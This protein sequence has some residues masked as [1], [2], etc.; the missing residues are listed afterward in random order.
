MITFSMDPVTHALAGAVLKQ[1]GFKRKWALGVL[2]LSSVA[3]DFD[4]ITRF[5]GMDIFLRYHRGI[6]HGIL[7]LL[8]VPAITGL[9]F[10]RKKGF[11]Y[12]YAISFLG[13]GS[14]LLMDLTTQ[15][16]TRILS[17]LDW[18]QYS[19]DL[20]FIIDPYITLGLLLCVIIG[21]LNI[22]KAPVIAALTLVLLVSY[23]G[24]RHY[25]HNRAEDFLRARVD[26]NTY[27]MCPLPNGFLRWWFVTRSGDEIMTGVADLFLQ[28]ICIQEKYAANP[29]N[30]LI[31]RSKEERAVKNFLYFAK[32]PQA[33]VRKEG[34]KTVV[35]WRELAYSFRAGDHF[36]TK[37][38][39]DKDGKVL[40]SEFR[41]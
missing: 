4:Y 22:K 3:P 25:L 5:W 13:Y 37:V 17:P 1:L 11:L 32:Y 38:V 16:G 40:K 34:E 29:D 23:F 14:H 26:A 33:E 9:L 39:F 28:R 18:E 6:T 2:L 24:L 10:G 12:Y 41:F 31:N 7:A 36:A 8:V 35:I 19:L 21:R 20:T 27:K 30:P 15:Y